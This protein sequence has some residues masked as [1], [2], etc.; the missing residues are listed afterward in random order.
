MNN[1]VIVTTSSFAALDTAP[2]DI[3]R[4]NGLHVTLNPHGKTLTTSE[5]IELCNN[6]AGIIAGTEPLN[7]IFF[8]ACPDLR[9]ISRCGT[10][11]D[12]VDIDAAT[13][14]G[15]QVFNTPD[16]PALA[17]A[18]LT[19]GMMLDLLR[20]ISCQDAE[21]RR[22]N[23]QKQMGF[24]LTGKRVGFI[25][26]GRIAQKVA[27]LLSP[28]DCQIAFSDI[29]TVSDDGNSIR[30]EL[31]ALLSWADII[32]IHAAAKDPL[33]GARELALMQPGSWLVNTARGRAVD[34][35]ALI[36][37]LNNGH[38]AGA[39]L[40]VFAQE[41]YEGALCGLNN[42]VLTPH[43]GSYAHESRILMEMEASRNLL[44]GLERVK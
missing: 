17:V 37:A 33:V 6:A 20:R 23:C 1:Q 25:G 41:P 32:S 5:A 28:F 8:E 9:V 4:N 10:G 31:D 40:D 21:M 34:E 30:M 26:F 27:K 44:K 43:I 24:Q 3:L 14:R 29:A 19:L 38:L 35:D 7:S 16:A 15:I 36:E 2:L 42:V 11:M 13:Q 39:A 12:N 22:G 18:E